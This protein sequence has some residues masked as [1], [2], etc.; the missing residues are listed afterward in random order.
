[1]ISDEADVE[2]IETP[3]NNEDLETSY[4]ERKPRSRERG[5]DKK[6]RTY[7][8]NSMRNLEQFSERP[9]EFETYLKDEKGIDISGKTSTAKIVLIVIGIVLA[10][11]CVLYFYDKHRNRQDTGE[12][13]QQPPNFLFIFYQ[14]GFDNYQFGEA[15]YQFGLGRF[16]FGIFSEM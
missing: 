11:L 9:Q 7:R 2:E 10:G 16:L 8:A 5:P 4:K 14:F 3:G 1:M 13:W 6:P 12:N 15:K